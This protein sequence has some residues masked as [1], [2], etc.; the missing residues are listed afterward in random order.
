MAQFLQVPANGISV[1]CT[2]ICPEPE[3]TVVFRSMGWLFIMI[4]LSRWPAKIV[5]SL[6]TILTVLADGR[7]HD[8][9][10]FFVRSLSNISFDF[11]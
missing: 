9:G 2:L 7:G 3:V 10:C 8:D 6:L 1:I 11:T 4:K 5:T